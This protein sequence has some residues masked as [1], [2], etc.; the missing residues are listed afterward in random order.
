M[1]ETTVSRRR[2]LQGAGLA[3]AAG[4]FAMA[5]TAAKADTEDSVVGTWR[6]TG[7]A[8]GL[9]TSF[10]LLM[11]FSAGGTVFSSAAIDL[12]PA[13]LSTPSYGAWKATGDGTYAFK[14]E[15]FTPDGSGAARGKATVDDDRIH[16][17]LAITLFDA[18]GKTVA[19]IP[20]SATGHRI[21][22]D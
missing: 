5:P 7:S 18:S 11:T 13:F 4:L 14:F 20:G 2:V 19:A 21:E 1:R 16:I 9:P 3:G 8:P 17:T 12:Q 22:V 6:A 15:F 10:G